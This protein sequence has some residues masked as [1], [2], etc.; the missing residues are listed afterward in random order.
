MQLGAG[1][2]GI[3]H[4][5]A[6]TFRWM[7]GDGHLRVTPDRPGRAFLRLLVE[8]GPSVG[9][10][11]AVTVLRDRQGRVVQRST[12]VGRTVWVVPLQL[13]SG[14]SDYSIS[15]ASANKPVPGDK[16]ILNLRLFG[17]SLQR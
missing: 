4:F 6:Q 7:D 15:V 10:N 17:A 11:R 5:N 2:Y 14:A 1:W 16:R 3:E 8:V 12:L 9:S 13:G